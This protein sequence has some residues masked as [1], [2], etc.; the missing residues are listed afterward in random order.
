MGKIDLKSR[1]AHSQV[2]IIPHEWLSRSGE[3]KFPHEW[4]SHEWGNF[5]LT[6]PAKPWVGDNFALGICHEWG[7]RNFSRYQFSSV[8]ELHFT[9]YGSKINLFVQ[10]S[11]NCRL[12]SIFSMNWLQFHYFHSP[13]G[14]RFWYFH[15]PMGDSFG[16]F[17]S[18]M[19]DG[20]VIHRWRTR[21]PWVTDSSTMDERFYYGNHEVL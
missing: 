15:S 13:M 11:Y 16:C 7:M 12:K 19:G 17:H 10:S 2:K 4:R 5:F 1:V 6:T 9:I 8:G 18:P 3:K 20:L 14:D 21:H